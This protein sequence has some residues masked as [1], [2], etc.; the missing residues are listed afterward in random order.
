MSL[1]DRLSGQRVNTPVR[2]LQRPI[3]V[4][5]VK[6][7]QSPGFRGAPPSDPSTLTDLVLRLSRLGEDLQAVAELDLNPVL[8]L[9]E[10]CV[11]VDARIRVR[12]PETVARAKTW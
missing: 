7:V 8:G 11:A 2:H 6:P 3:W 10:G 1:D 4:T 5:C 12:K 9:S